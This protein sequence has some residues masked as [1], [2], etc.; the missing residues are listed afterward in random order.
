MKKCIFYLLLMYLSLVLLS[1]SSD[2]PPPV[3]G[4]TIGT[5]TD[6]T[7]GIATV[8]ILKTSNGGTNWVLQTLPDECAG[9]QGN[10]ISAVN[11]QVAWAAIADTRVTS[12]DGGILHT[13]D[14]GTTWALQTLPAG[15]ITRQ[16]KGIKG[17][18]PTEAWAVSI[19]GDVLHTTNVGVTWNIVPVR[20]INGNIITMTQ[21]NRMDVISPDIW[22]VD[23][24]TGNLGVIHS[25]DGG[26]TWRQEFVPSIDIGSNGPLAVSG[27]NTL[28]A[29]TAVNLTGHLWW[30]SNGGLTWNKS[31]DS[32]TGGA[33]YDDICASSADV[34][35][36]A[37]NGGGLNGGFTARVRVT[38]G[39]FQSHVTNHPPYMMEGVSPLTDNKAWAVGFRMSSIPSDLPAGAIFY[40]EDG[41][42]T[43]QQ[44]TMP[45]NARDVELWKVSFAGAR[46]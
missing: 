21:V 42:V 29:W 32:L 31:I 43:W 20:D 24:L 4:W 27:I 25:P 33:D 1:C 44:Q 38:N 5:A 18:S 17:V 13:A 28:R 35:W 2:A 7:T 34:V 12:S 10:D 30:T 41:G 8:K 15:M 36:I 3:T 9:M 22:I 11:H 14:G 37:C 26:A 39:S 6:N 46:R 19:G 16:I 40:T 45:A 23:P